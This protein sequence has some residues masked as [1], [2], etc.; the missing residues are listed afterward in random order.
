MPAKKGKKFTQKMELACLHFAQCGDKSAA[1]KHAYNCSNTKP[2]TINNLAYRLFNR[3]DVK[4]R[5]EELKKEAA[6]DAIMGR[7]EALKA[8]S[9]I[10]RFNIGRIADFRPVQMGADPESGEPITAYL[11]QAKDSDHI[12]PADTKMIKSVT[13]G[14]N[15]IKIESYSRTDA[16]QQL[17]RMQGWESAD[18]FKELQGLNS[19]KGRNMADFYDDIEAEEE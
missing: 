19:D 11:F 8:L 9:E 12:D 13:C 1:Y 10:A 17:A 7:E 15:G 6:S 3:D 14:K 18:K 5:V 2:A 4:A 16:I